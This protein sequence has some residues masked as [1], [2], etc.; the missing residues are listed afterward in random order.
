MRKT[1]ESTVKLRILTEK[2]PLLFGERP[3]EIVR[4]VIDR[5]KGQI[6]RHAYFNR[7]EISYNDKLFDELGITKEYR[8]KK[9]GIDPEKGRVFFEENYEKFSRREIISLNA[10]SKKTFDRVRKTYNMSQKKYFTKGEMQSRNHG[11][12]GY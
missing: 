2:S 11:H 9:P 3:N 1:I 8:I 4:H 7:G 12:S 10:V 5:N 6:L